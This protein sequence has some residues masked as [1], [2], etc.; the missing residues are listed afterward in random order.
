MA[1]DT[2]RSKPRP[3]QSSPP[4][5]AILEGGQPTELQLIALMAAALANRPI[6]ELTKAS[7]LP[8]DDAWPSWPCEHPDWL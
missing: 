6:S 3:S 4:W 1:R 7:D 5:R 2:R 8:R